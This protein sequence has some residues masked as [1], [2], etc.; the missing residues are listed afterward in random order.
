MH[1]HVFL[2]CDRNGNGNVREKEK[3]TNKGTGKQEMAIYL[4]LIISNFCTK[5]YLPKLS[6]SCEIS[7]F[8]IQE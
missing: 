4:F 7:I 8:I 5:F 2:M 1:G 6:S 3:W